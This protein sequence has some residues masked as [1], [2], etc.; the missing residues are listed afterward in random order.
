[1]LGFAK[2]RKSSEY[3]NIETSTVHYFH[4]NVQILYYELALTVKTVAMM[5]YHKN[6]VSFRTDSS[7][8]ICLG[9]LSKLCL[10]S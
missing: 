5:A 1:M 8:N 2:F 3:K 6:A 10:I 9:V 7:S 4:L